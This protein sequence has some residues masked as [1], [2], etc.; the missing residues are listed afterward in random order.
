[1]GLLQ[2]KRSSGLRESLVLKISRGKGRSKNDHS[3]EKPR[4][5][6]GGECG[7]SG[8][9]SVERPRLEYLPNLPT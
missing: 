7:R 9:Q 1:M 8:R 4:R 6:A 3:W 5:D 2:P